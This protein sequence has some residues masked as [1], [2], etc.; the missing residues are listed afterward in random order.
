MI[1]TILVLDWAHGVGLQHCCSVVRG[2]DGAEQ[3][4][5]QREG[6]PPFRVFFQSFLFFCFFDLPREGT[7]AIVSLLYRAHAKDRRSVP[8]LA[9]R[10][11]V[12]FF[13]AEIYQMFLYMFM[14]SINEASFKNEVTQAFAVASRHV[15]VAWEGAGRGS[16][17]GC[18]ARAHPT[19]A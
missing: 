3:T 17:G 14:L 15:L 11:I 16:C 1:T 4:M 19:P 18:H 6:A 10:R 12:P 7:S 5:L 13:F 2:Y 8:R 9:S